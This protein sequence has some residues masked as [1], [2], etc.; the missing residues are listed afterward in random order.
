[1][2]LFEVSK[3]WLERKKYYVVPQRPQLMVMLK[4]VVRLSSNC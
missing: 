4:T 2:E 3:G 1:M